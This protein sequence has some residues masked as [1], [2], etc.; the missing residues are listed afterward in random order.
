MPHKSANRTAVHSKFCLC[1]AGCKLRRA[2]NVQLP[3]P[4]LLPPSA[5]KHICFLWDIDR[6]HSLQEA[7]EVGL[8]GPLISHTDSA[9]A[10]Q[11]TAAVT[12]VERS[13]CVLLC[14]CDRTITHCVVGTARSEVPFGRTIAPGVHVRVSKWPA[15]SLLVAFWEVMPSFAR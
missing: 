2:L 3:S 5:R 11:I 7:M 13:S 10:C 15:R 1:H 6:A 9:R 12:I 14:L 4:S 8:H